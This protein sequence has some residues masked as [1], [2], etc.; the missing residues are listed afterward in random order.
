MVLQG[1]ELIGGGLLLLILNIA[2]WAFAWGRT[3]GKVC[4]TVDNLE[5]RVTTQEASQCSGEV[6]SSCQEIFRS[7][8]GRLSSVEAK[9]DI[10]LGRE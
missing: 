4:E 2:F 8:E 1:P 9:L 5:Q 7:I 3:V 6:L 10:I